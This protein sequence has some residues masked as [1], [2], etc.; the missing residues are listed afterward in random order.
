M[1]K[2]ALTLAA[3][4]IVG[5]CTSE[6][7]IAQEASLTGRKSQTGSPQL[8]QSPQVQTGRKVAFASL[9]DRGT[10]LAF[11]R[12]QKPAHR[13]AYTYHAVQLSEAHALN[14]AAAGKS[15][16]LPL[17]SGETMRIAYQ[18]HEEGLDGNW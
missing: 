6:T 2:L 16:D 8:A 11:D 7:E 4:L 10:L 15:I 9:P 18:R 1:R 12:G 14:A 13:A 3:A 5:G 17:P